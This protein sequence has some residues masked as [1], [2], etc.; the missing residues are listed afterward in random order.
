M[1]SNSSDHSII[2]GQ[3][4]NCAPDR[5]GL[6]VCNIDKLEAILESLMIADF[7][8]DRHWPMGFG[9]LKLQL[10]DFTEID[11]TGHRRSHAAFIYVPGTA[12]QYSGRLD[13]QA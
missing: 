12:V 10:D 6:L 5:L 4:A 2:N 13:G 9:Q 3:L 1:K 8:M 11:V 7:S